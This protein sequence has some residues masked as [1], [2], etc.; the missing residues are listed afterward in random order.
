MKV[1]A[2]MLACCIAAT[3]ASPLKILT[4][5]SFLRFPSQLQTQH[6]Y[7]A[8]NG[9]KMAKSSVGS[10]FLE[11]ENLQVPKTVDWREKGYVTPVKNQRWTRLCSHTSF[12]IYKTGAYTEANCSSSQL[13][14]GVLV[15]YGVENGQDYWLVKN[16]W[17]ASW[18]EAKYIKM[19]R[20]HDNQ[21]GIASQ[22]SYP[23]L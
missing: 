6:E 18:G 9:Y 2:V 12:Q 17:G 22:A 15:G 16:S 7:A 19:A 20:N 8:L 10:S 5:R 11:P 3:L 1:F 21:C 4:F 13:D 23:L 14:H